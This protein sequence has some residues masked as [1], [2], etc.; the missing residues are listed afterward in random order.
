[1]IIRYNTTR[2]RLLMIFVVVLFLSCLHSPSITGKWQE[3]GKAGTLEF[4]DDNTFNAVDD[5]GMAVSGIYHLDDSENLCLEI[6]HHEAPPE[7]INLQIKIEEDK[8]TF[9]YGGKEIDDKY[10]RVK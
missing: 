4:N 6:K 10:K 1:M 2:W 3:I 9:I 7:V 5:M 8:L